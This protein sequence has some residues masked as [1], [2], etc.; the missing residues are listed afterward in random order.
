MN[1]PSTTPRGEHA[2]RPG[3]RWE[4]QLQ[5]TGEHV[6]ADDQP[7]PRAN[8]AARRAARKERTR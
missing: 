4:T 8:R 5:P 2:G 7:Q 1:G 6:I 3:A